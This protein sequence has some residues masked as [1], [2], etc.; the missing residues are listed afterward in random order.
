MFRR[1]YDYSGDVAPHLDPANNFQR[2]AELFNS[3]GSPKFNIDW[4]KEATTTAFSNNSSLSFSSGRERL[5][6]F[7]NISFNDQQGIMLNSD[8]KRLNAFANIIGDARPWLHLQTV[9]TAG[10]QEGGNVDLNLFG[11]NAIREMYEFLPFLPVRYADGTYSMKGDYPNAENS[12]NPVK[13]LNEVKDKTGN[14]YGNGSFVMTANLGKKFDLTSSWGGQLNASFHNYYSN[15]D[16]F[17]YSLTQ[18]GVAQRTN[19]FSTGWTNED[20]LT[21]HDQFGRH[22]LNIV[23]GASWYYNSV[24]STFAGSENYFDDHFTYNSLQTG[25]VYEQ[26]TS[27]QISYSFNSYYL[28][29]NYNFDDRYLLGASMRADGSSRFGANNKY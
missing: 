6:S 17:G 15:K 3:D 2:K 24:N 13:L 22:S 27:S 9:I 14:I 5:S 26:P 10:G 29:A 20:Y 7:F 8:L 21:Y 16:V 12:E 4:Q 18:N 11:L 25:T 1:V 28:R 19:G 23:G